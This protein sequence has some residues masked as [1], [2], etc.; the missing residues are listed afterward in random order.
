M[1]DV[2]AD[3]RAEKK[4]PNSNTQIGVRGIWTL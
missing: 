2:S 1:D 4:T 3:S